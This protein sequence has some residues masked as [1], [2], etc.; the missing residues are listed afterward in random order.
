MSW[1]LHA[2]CTVYLD[3]V[4]GCIKLHSMGVW[5]S[6]LRD[7]PGLSHVEFE[8]KQLQLLHPLEQSVI[9]CILIVNYK[10]FHRFSGTV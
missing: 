1:L 6:Q 3:S 7:N 2:F 5:G 9:L 10:Q 8:Q 4:F